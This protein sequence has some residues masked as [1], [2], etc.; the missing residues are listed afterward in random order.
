MDEMKPSD[1][2]TT[3]R[4][5]IVLGFI[6]LLGI[7]YAAGWYFASHYKPETSVPVSTKQN[8]QTSNGDPDTV[9]VNDVLWQKSV[10]YTTRVMLVNPNV[11]DK[12]SDVQNSVEIS[13]IGEFIRGKYKGGKLIEIFAGIGLMATS[14][15]KF[16]ELNS[17]YIFLEKESDP[18]DYDQ[19][20]NE[21]K[22]IRNNYEIDSE[23]I[24]P[25]LDFPGT[26]NTPFGIVLHRDSP[27]A[28]RGSWF[29]MSK[30]T[31]MFRDSKWGDIYMEGPNADNPTHGFYL[32]TPYGVGELYYLIPPFMGL[33][34][35]LDVKWNGEGRNSTEYDYSPNNG[36][37]DS[38]FADVVEVNQSELAQTGETITGDQVY[39]YKNP[40]NPALKNVY[41]HNYFVYGDQEKMP[42]EQFVGIHSVFFWKD[43]FGRMIRFRNA[44]FVS[45]AE[46]G[47]PVIYLYPQSTTR[48]SV[49]LDPKGGFSASD[50]P[51]NKGWNIIAAPDSRL[52][53]MKSG[54]IYPY[55]FWE[56]R[57][58]MYKSPK[59]GFI[60]KQSNVH[61]FLVE[62]LGLLGLNGKETSDFIEFWE[63]RMHDSPYYFVGF[64][65][66]RIM[67]ELAPL[68]IEPKPD[69][70]I[71]ILMD[72]LPLVEP[73]PVQEPI[74]K[75][76]IRSGF[77]VVEWGGVLR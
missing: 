16:V 15:H 11:Y 59:N 34:N 25:E 31:I 30:A 60:V 46:C 65:G 10:P 56:G 32:R 19:L 38:S 50:P 7:G 36:C 26:L 61:D 74:I 68:K 42:Y 12:P 47:K 45:Q 76:P 6:I 70:V 58:G 8:S 29:D 41:E 37:G 24:I 14:S 3:D 71:R 63:P 17:R 67:D 44:M 54:K 40:N 13:L 5:T 21:E 39:E 35:I 77:T 33:D 20:D 1:A 22:P 53:E 2:G 55:L 57:G 66:N 48:I 43:P 9:L 62:K 51:Y 23:Y 28:R 69:T 72:F 4:A 75:T 64:H 27:G 18:L 49:Q 52:T 73:I